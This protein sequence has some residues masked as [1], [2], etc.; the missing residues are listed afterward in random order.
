MGQCGYRL[1]KDSSQL[2]V[3]PPFWK[4]YLLFKKK[5]AY[6]RRLSG[7]SKVPAATLIITL[8]GEGMA[9]SFRN[10]IAHHWEC[11]GQVSKAQETNTCHGGQ[12]RTGCGSAELI[13]RSTI[14]LRPASASW[15]E[16]TS[17]WK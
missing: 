1:L 6:L 9:P 3:T 16:L 8:F 11:Q 7:C 4:D 10:P 14:T 13:V 17:A 12:Y 5:L 15:R 2:P